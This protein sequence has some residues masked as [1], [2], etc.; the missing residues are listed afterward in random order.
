M[1]LDLPPFGL[2]TVLAPV[3]R[4]LA[5]LALLLRLGASFVGASSMMFR[6]AQL[7]VYKSFLKEGAFTPDQLR[8]L[9]DARDEAAAVAAG[10]R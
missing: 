2:Y 5:Q 4:Q 8:T 1:A 10:R 6:V 9:S 3:G 7:R